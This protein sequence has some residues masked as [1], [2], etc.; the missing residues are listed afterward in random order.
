MQVVLY[1]FMPNKASGT[2]QHHNT[3]ASQKH[4]RQKGKH[5]M[6]T[7]TK[8]TAQAK[9][10]TTTASF[11]TVKRNYETALASGKD[12]AQEL[13]ALATAVAYSVINKCISPKERMPFFHINCVNR[14]RQWAVS[15]SRQRSWTLIIRSGLPEPLSLPAIQ[16]FIL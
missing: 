3:T 9:A 1:L 15:L 16:R 6:N 11:E 14:S 2:P 4:Q 10:N 7:N 8:A 13:T 12:T 5:K